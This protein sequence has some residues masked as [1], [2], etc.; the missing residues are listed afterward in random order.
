M[1]KLLLVSDLNLVHCNEF[2]NQETETLWI[3]KIKS[4]KKGEAQIPNLN[5]RNY[6]PYPSNNQTK[7]I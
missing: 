2:P 1:F 5:D 4:F 3:P 7:P 6:E